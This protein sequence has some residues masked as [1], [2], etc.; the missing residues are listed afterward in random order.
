MTAA[1]ILSQLQAVGVGIRLHGDSLVC[2]PLRKVPAEL[3][4]RRLASL[5]VV[6]V[7]MGPDRRGGS[8]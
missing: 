2:K 1:E 7:A 8:W 5:L 6:R 3:A 4:Q